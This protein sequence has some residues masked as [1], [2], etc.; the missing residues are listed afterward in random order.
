ML[1][2]STEKA[3]DLRVRRTRMMIQKAFTEL[4]EEKGFQ[5]VTVQDIA[6]RAM[7]N[8]A[9]FYDHFTDKYALFEHTMREWFRETLISKLPDDFQYCTGNIQFLI[10]TLCEFIVQIDEHCR[11]NNTQG[12]PPFDE[13][14]TSLIS[15][16][17]VKWFAGRE[18]VGSPELVADV[19]SWAMYGAAR[20]W[21]L[22][23]Q[24]EPADSFAMRAAPMIT[25]M[26][27]GQTAT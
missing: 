23:K 15:E 5:A 16:Q 24:R 14:I 17:L 21:S 12:L 25:A 7:V 1:V 19:A 6:D 2:N 13:Q 22:Q 9:T 27:Q 8:R 26:M 11:H 4:L 18:G 20:H 10:A 3:P